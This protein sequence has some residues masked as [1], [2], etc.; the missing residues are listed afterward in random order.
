MEHFKHMIDVH[1]GNIG[2]HKEV[3]GINLTTSANKDHKNNVGMTF[4]NDRESF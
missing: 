2:H 1:R 4:T 3:L